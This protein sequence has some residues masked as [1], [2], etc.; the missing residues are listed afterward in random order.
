LVSRAGETRVDVLGRTAFDG[1]ELRRTDRPG[2]RSQVDEPEPVVED[3]PTTEPEPGNDSAP[4][5]ADP[6]PGHIRCPLNTSN[7]DLPAGAPCPVATTT[8]SG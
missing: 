1:P 2:G 8:Q 5:D 7:S 3:E 6:K 4:V